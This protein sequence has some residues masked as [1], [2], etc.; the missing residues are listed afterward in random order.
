MGGVLEK[1]QRE[2]QRLITRIERVRQTWE[3]EIE[4]KDAP[5]KGFRDD[6]FAEA[7][8]SVSKE[9]FGKKRPGKKFGRDLAR[10]SRARQQEQ[11]E[12]KRKE[13][14]LALAREM[15][16]LIEEAADD[17]HPQNLRAFRRRI[18][19]AKS[20]VKPETV[21]RR[22]RAEAETFS[23]YEPPKSMRGDK[24]KSQAADGEARQ[25]LQ[26]LERALRDF[27]VDELSSA[28]EDWWKE[29]IPSDI[30]DNTERRRESRE[31]PSPWDDSGDHRPIDYVDFPD[32]GK[33]LL[34]KDNWRDTFKHHFQDK[35]VLQAKL[36]ELQPIRND[37]AH[38]RD[39]TDKQRQKL[40]LH[41]EEILDCIE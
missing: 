10:S 20:A 21:L 16:Q 7:A 8:G 14:A 40:R 33:I 30:R 11:L 25:L 5:L 17:I 28:S 29:R 31:K 32:Y 18:G 41:A 38:S 19:K 15:E 34:R 39:L 26:R 2:A 4:P 37:V 35:T 27:I 6:L 24:D 23:V 9:L 3:N 13:Q 36:R 22:T 12:A 1:A